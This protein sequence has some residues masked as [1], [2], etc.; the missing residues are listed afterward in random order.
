MVFIFIKL[1]IVFLLGFFFQLGLLKY[2]NTSF[3]SLLNSLILK[4]N[5]IFLAS[6]LSG[7]VVSLYFYNISDELLSF[8][9]FSLSTLILIA[10]S[11]VDYYYQ[12]IPPFLPFLLLILGLINI[13]LHYHSVLSYVLSGVIPGVFLLVIAI[14]SNGGVGGGDI[15]L[16]VPLGFVLGAELIFLTFFNSYLI[17]LV[18]LV[19]LLFF[20]KLTFKSYLPYVPF[21]TIGAIFS[22]IVGV[23][24]QALFSLH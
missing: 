15:K 1:L 13:A 12:E 23:P 21:L 9:L 17:G 2:L 24:F 14:V 11:F 20:K 16:I 22:I 8:V 4:K 6:L 10:A 5:S 3:Y 7:L 19:P 18:I